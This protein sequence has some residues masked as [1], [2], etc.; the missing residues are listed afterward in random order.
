MQDIRTAYYSSAAAVSLAC[1]AAELSLGVP[2]C[3]SH[4]LNIRLVF[5]V[6]Q[7][8]LVTITLLL[9]L[10]S[11]MQQPYPHAEGTWKIIR[12]ALQLNYE[13]A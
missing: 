3:F 8:T 1:P 2:S 4:E 7:K 6:Q 12:Y 10:V 5:V 11:L 13:I 9:I